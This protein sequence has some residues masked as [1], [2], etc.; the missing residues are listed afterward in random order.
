ME[1]DSSKGTEEKNLM[2][3]VVRNN[4]FHSVE[5][6]NILASPSSEDIIWLKTVM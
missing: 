1:C 3:R 4:F 5:H 2:E 6:N